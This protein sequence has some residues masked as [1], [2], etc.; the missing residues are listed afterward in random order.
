[1]GYCSAHTNKTIICYTVFNDKKTVWKYFIYIWE[2]KIVW[3]ALVCWSIKIYSI[4]T[5]IS[6]LNFTF[7]TMQSVTYHSSLNT[8]PGLV[9]CQ[10]ETYDL[11]C[12]IN[13]FQCF[14]VQWRDVLQHCIRWLELHLVFKGLDGDAQPWKNLCTGLELVWAA[15]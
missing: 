13:H 11:S 12:Q 15:T 8:K 5:K 4:G 6:A 14:R 2:R 9:H 1:M 3:C 10:T 7:D